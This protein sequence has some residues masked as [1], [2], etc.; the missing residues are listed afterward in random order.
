MKIGQEVVV[1]KDFK[2]NTTNSEK[3]MTIKKGDR[4]YLDSKGRVHLTT[5]KGKG[6]I[7]NAKNI[8]LKGYDHENIAV[9]IY[10][11]LNSLYGLGMMIEENNI[12]EDEFIE[13]IEDVLSDML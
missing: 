11:R 5:G 7:I 10:H 13:E 6:K 4:G 1:E 8:K 12:D 3:V 9:A 2:I